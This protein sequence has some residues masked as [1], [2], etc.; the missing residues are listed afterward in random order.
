MLVRQE[1]DLFE[2]LVETRQYRKLATGGTEHLRTDRQSFDP[3]GNPLT[4][5]D[6]AGSASERFHNFV[7]DADDRL[8]QDFDDGLPGCADDQ[9]LETDYLGTGWV[10]REAIRK[11]PATCE[12]TGWPTRQVTTSAYFRNGDLEK[13]ETFKG[14]ESDPANLV[15]SHVLSYVTDA[16]VYANGHRLKD[17]F[18]QVGPGGSGPCGTTACTATYAYDARDRLVGWSNGLP[19]GQGATSIAYTLDADSAGVDTLAGNV[20]R[21]AVTEN[22]QAQAAKEYAYN[23]GGQLET[24]T[25]G[26]T[27]TEKYFYERGNLRC[28]TGPDGSRTIDPDGTVTCHG[29]LLETYSWD[30]LDRLERFTSNGQRGSKAQAVDYVYD[31]FDR[32]VRATETRGGQ[33]QPQTT[34][35]YLGLT[36]AVSNETQGT[37][38]KRYGYD[39]NLS[40]T[41]VSVTGGPNPGS[42]TY[43]R[44]AHGDVSLLLQETGGAKAA[45]GYRPYGDKDPGLF[46]GDDD[47]NPLNP[48]RFNDRRLDTGS[49]LIDMGARRFA[50][51][52]GRFLEQD[53]YR[54]ALSDVELSY[55]ALTEN[56]YGFAGG[57]PISFVETDGHKPAPPYCAPYARSYCQAPPTLKSSWRESIQYWGQGRAEDVWEDL[58][59]GTG[60]LGVV[61]GTLGR[62]GSWAF[63]RIT[64]RTAGD[65]VLTA[66]QRRIIARLAAQQAAINASRTVLSTPRARGLA[67]RF[68]LGLSKK[69]IDNALASFEGEI[70]ARIV[71]KGESFLR[72]TSK[73]RG[74]GSYLTKDMFGSPE[75]PSRL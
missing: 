18:K 64:G 27:L 7:H 68:G 14:L 56:R 74:K 60:S 43:G 15:E 1:Y 51:D 8:V 31:A 57:N 72:Y 28:A 40:R 44:N 25:E 46:A 4:H 59:F 61:R 67:K 42:Y 20:T 22:G 75:L 70:T 5:T 34:L 48:F 53:F 52:T 29:T 66:A 38:T 23:G 54:E 50:P 45:Y 13:Q 21:E 24:L 62:A 10:S 9:V 17:V 16:G 33:E 37:V 19:S 35:E 3:H 47:T 32:P 71:P 26:G 63:G 69:R 2:E 65:E 11:R 55:D 58:F 6:D 73:R 12:Q 41:G 39:A 36:D 49:G 30:P